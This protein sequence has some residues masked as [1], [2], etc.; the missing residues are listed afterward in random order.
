[1][2]TT[3]MIT[4]LNMLDAAADDDDVNQWKTE[5]NIPS[6]AR[7]VL[8][9]LMHT[10]LGGNTLCGIIIIVIISKKVVMIGVSSIELPSD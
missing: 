9:S 1:M 8:A 5:L 2:T 10:M 3:M 4:K 7:I 6:P